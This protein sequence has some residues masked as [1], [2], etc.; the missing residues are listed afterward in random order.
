MVVGWGII[1]LLGATTLTTSPVVV[2]GALRSN[3]TRGALPKF[4]REFSAKMAEISLE[5]LGKAHSCA[6]EPSLG[7]LNVIYVISCLEN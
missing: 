5:N 3:F 4:S 6:I 2:R 7:G 1:T